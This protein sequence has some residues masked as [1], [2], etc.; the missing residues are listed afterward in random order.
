MLTAVELQYPG[1]KSMARCAAAAS[2]TNPRAWQDSKSL[3]CR[4]Q[5]FLMSGPAISFPESTSRAYCV[6]GSTEELVERVFFFFSTIHF[7][8]SFWRPESGPEFNQVTFKTSI[9]IR[10][11]CYCRVSLNQKPALCLH[12]V[13]S[14]LVG[15]SQAKLQ[16]VGVNIAE[17][18]ER[19]RIGNG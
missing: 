8:P 9:C 11:H 7:L 10:Q 18:F 15:N 16:N 2:H 13:S 1:K 19:Q 14:P 3:R 12:G 6:A 4:L 17:S 5:A